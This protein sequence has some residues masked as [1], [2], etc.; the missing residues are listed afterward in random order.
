MKNV[1]RASTN[2]RGWVLQERVLSPRVLHFSREQVF[3]ECR[4][5][6]ACESFPDN[7]DRGLC[8]VGH[9]RGAHIKDFVPGQALED[10]D[11]QSN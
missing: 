9:L 6:R 3:W 8:G 4:Q 11:D 10:Y 7:V 1:E 2:R 5:L